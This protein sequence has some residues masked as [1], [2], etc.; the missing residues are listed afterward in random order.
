MCDFAM[1]LKLGYVFGALSVSIYKL[2]LISFSNSF[3]VIFSLYPWNNF[4]I[5]RFLPI[6]K[7][8]GTTPPA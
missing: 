1:L 7:N 5:V 4:V 2:R 6:M 3:P 8:W